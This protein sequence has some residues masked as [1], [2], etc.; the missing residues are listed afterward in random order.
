M[1]SLSPLFI[2]SNNVL[3]LTEA[4][5]SL[6]HSFKKMQSHFTEDL[7]RAKE[8]ADHQKYKIK[9]AFT[10]EIM[11]ELLWEPFLEPFEQN[12]P[13]VDLIYTYQDASEQEWPDADLVL[14]HEMMRKQNHDREGIC[15][16]QTTGFCWVSANHPIAKRGSIVRE[17]LNNYPILTIYSEKRF[18]EM[19]KGIFDFYQ[20]QPS[21]IIQVTSPLERSIWML[22]KNAVTFGDDHTFTLDQRYARIHLPDEITR[23]SF[24]LYWNPLSKNPVL[25]VLVNDMKQLYKGS[26]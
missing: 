10:G 5:K 15:L 26:L 22:Q 19:S 14:T 2:R 21:R 24:Y 23:I 6:Y 20:V 1:G 4:G 12:N 11:F 13:E 8:I 3:E 16:F 18:L 17:D 9:I 7:R 25:P